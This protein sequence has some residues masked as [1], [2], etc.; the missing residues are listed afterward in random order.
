[1]KMKEQK[2]NKKNV[3]LIKNVINKCRY[4]C[5]GLYYCF[6]SPSSILFIIVLIMSHL[7]F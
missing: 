5:D 2:G 6:N 4:T 3:S 7:L 1:M